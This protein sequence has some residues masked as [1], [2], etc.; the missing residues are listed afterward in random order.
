MLA[1]KFRLHKKNDFDSLIKSPNKFYSKSF[2]VK[3]IKNNKSFN[4]FAVVVS[5][6]ISLRAVIRN[7]LRRQIFE[8][9]RLNINTLTKGFNIVIFVKK[10]SL[11]MNYSELEKEL[12]YIFKKA[13]LIQ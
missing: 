4:S 2:V 11:K 9:I 13:T 1:K 3:F 7:K 8:I 12:L 6:K 5:K 10:G